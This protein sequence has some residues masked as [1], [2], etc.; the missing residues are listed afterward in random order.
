MLTGAL[1]VPPLPVR[2]PNCR[3]HRSRCRN[4]P[5]QARSSLWTLTAATNGTFGRDCTVDSGRRQVAGTHQ[6]IHIRL[7]KKMGRTH[8]WYPL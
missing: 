2:L 5:P 7:A 6:I 1:D 4:N 3:L 8:R